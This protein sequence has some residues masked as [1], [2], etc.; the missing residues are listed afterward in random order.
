M[1][2][3]RC[4][5]V[6]CLFCSSDWS[7]L[8]TLQNLRLKIDHSGNIFCNLD[9]NLKLILDVSRSELPCHGQNEGE[10]RRC[11][12]RFLFQKFSL[13]QILWC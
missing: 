7:V 8:V 1:R 6:P 13:F 5:N 10:P 4:K 11:V 12:N 3:Q 9:V 2:P